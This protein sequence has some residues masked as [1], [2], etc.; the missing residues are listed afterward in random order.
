M[1]FPTELEA[2]RAY[3]KTFPNNTTLLIDTYNP[4][5]GAKNAAIVAK[6]LEAQG[7]RLGAVRLDSGDIAGDS[8]QIRELFDRMGLGYVKI[9]ASN[10]LNENK[11]AEMKQKGA[12]ID[13]YGVGTEMITAKPVAALGGVYKLVEDGQGPKIKLAKDKIT[14]P[15]RKQVFRVQDAQGN[16]NYD[17]LALA[18]ERV[19]G[20]PLLEK[21]VENGRRIVPARTLQETRQYCLEEVAKLPAQARELNAV[22]YEMRTSPKLDALVCELKARYQ[23]GVTQ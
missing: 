6:E 5:E 10:D 14:Y 21:V 18:D 15:G 7:K 13:A 1:G 19:D 12:R 2:F 23:Q 3:V 17:V 4:I 22:P 16:Y 9:T 8:I 20:M 11:I